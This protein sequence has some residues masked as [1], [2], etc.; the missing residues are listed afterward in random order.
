MSIKLPGQ[1]V[2]ISPELQKLLEQARA[3]CRKK[4]KFAAILPKEGFEGRF[5]WRKTD[6]LIEMNPN[7]IPTM[8]EYIAAHELCHV[9]QL[10]R[11]CA[12]AAGRPDQPLTV[13]IATDITSLIYD[14]SADSIAT[15]AGLKMAS[16]FDTYLKS[17]G[18][19]EELNKVSNGRRYGTNWAR[20]WEWIKA[21]F[22]ARRAGVEA[23]RVPMRELWTL[24]LALKWAN[25]VQRAS[26]LALPVEFEIRESILKLPVVSE[27]LNDLLNI[28]A[29]NNSSNV[30]ESI[31]KLVSILEYIKVPPGH[32]FIAKPLTDEIFVEGQWRPRIKEKSIRDEL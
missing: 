22:V 29:L 9:L 26:N 18:L 15:L 13:T 20:I 32:I 28:G 24:D 1:T 3:E 4:I 11:G 21:E 30:E 2:S 16:G 6:V 12:I 31:N 14:A 7:L 8:A 25:V 10:A 19:L 27:V 5:N 23:P 17:K